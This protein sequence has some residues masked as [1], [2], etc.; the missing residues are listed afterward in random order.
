MLPAKLDS[1]VFCYC[2][3]RG[4][5]RGIKKKTALERFSFEELSFIF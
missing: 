5:E 3:K 2:A 4:E 1:N